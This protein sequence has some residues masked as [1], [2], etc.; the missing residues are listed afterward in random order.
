MTLNEFI[1][2]YKRSI[3][4]VMKFR[5]IKFV[6]IISDE[7]GSRVVEGLPS[8]DEDYEVIIALLSI[9]GSLEP[10]YHFDDNKPS[11]TLISIDSLRSIY[12][13]TKRGERLLQGRLD[14]EIYVSPPKFESYVYHAQALQERDSC[15]KGGAALLKIASIDINKYQSDI[16]LLEND[17]LLAA[18]ARFDGVQYPI[19][20]ATILE[21][22]ICYARS[23]SMV[24]ND[25]SY[26]IDFGLITKLFADKGVIS[27]EVIANYRSCLSEIKKTADSE[28][29]LYFLN[30]EQLVN[31]LKS[32]SDALNLN[33]PIASIFIFLKLQ[34]ELY[35]NSNLDKTSFHGLVSDFRVPERE[36]ELA[37]A[38][39]ILGACFGFEFF[40][41]NYYQSVKP[42]FLN[43][44]F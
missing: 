19:D 6:D 14:D 17:V 25:F 29:L 5:L 3:L 36:A 41:T 16:S 33:F 40:A 11:Y 23:K 9:N 44:E 26:L 28:T 7:I 8:Y 20:D 12:P 34:H 21:N 4:K 22:L 30:Q 13:I 24:T 2:F 32:F 31:L 43:L 35:E 42:E 37:I 27:D 10:L 39:W 18:K 38:L 1:L 15:L